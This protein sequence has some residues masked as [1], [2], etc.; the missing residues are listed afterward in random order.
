MAFRL[1]RPDA[2]GGI[3]K[4]ATLP[5]ARAERRQGKRR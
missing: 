4:K 5:P 3:A 2:K 1:R